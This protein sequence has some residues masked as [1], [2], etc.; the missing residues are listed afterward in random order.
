MNNAPLGHTAIRLV[1]GSGP[2]RGPIAKIKNHTKWF[3]L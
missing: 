2:Q 1:V 3:S